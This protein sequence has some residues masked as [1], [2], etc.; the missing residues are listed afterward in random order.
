MRR[1]D[2]LDRIINACDEIISAAESIKNLAGTKREKWKQRR[3]AYLNL[4]FNGYTKME[5]VLISISQQVGSTADMFNQAE[6]FMDQAQAH[7]DNP[8]TIQDPEPLDWFTNDRP[9]SQ[10][11]NAYVN[12]ESVMKQAERDRQYPYVWLDPPA[13]PK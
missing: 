10:G 12:P 2:H 9:D 1:K 5:D 8:Y 4:R 11:S 6:K 3:D 13:Q 7:I